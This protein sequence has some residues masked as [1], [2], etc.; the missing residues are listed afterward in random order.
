MMRYLRRKEGQGL[1]EYALILVLIAI[2]V[3]VILAT[4]GTRVQVLLAQI[5]FSLANPGQ[6]AGPP[7]SVTSISVNASAT[8]SFGSCTGVNASASV[9]L[10]DGVSAPVTIQFTNNSTGASSTVTGGS[11]GNL[12]SGTS[13]SSVTACVVGVQGYMLVGGGCASD[14]Y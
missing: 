1:V 4:L 12:G 9:S 8:C 10:S 5:E 14:T 7:V 2:I 11:S 13:G 3:I 6:T